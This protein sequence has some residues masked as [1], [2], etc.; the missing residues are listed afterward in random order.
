MGAA[1]ALP[2]LMMAMAQFS[3]FSLLRRGTVSTNLK[4]IV[5]KK[6]DRDLLPALED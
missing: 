4:K 5:R 2:M 3:R 1:M 6:K